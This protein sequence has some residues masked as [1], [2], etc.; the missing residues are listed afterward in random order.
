TAEHAYRFCHVRPGTDVAFFNG[1]MNVILAEGLYD[2]DFVARRTTGFA[3][4]AHTVAAYT[5]EVVAKLG[6]VPA[7]R[8]LEVARLV[9]RARAAM[10]FWGMGIS[11]HT[12]GTDNARCLISLCLLT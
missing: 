1:L 2:R 12:H 6:G 3:E 4:L 7:E 5:P 9:G 11:Q 8:M 10:I